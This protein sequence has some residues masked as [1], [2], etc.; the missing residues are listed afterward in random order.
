MLPSIFSVVIIFISI[1]SFLLTRSM[2]KDGYT[3]EKWFSSGAI[4]LHLLGLLACFCFI[5][6]TYLEHYW[7]SFSNVTQIVAILYR[8]NFRK[9]K[10]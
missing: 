9:T 2:R 10:K 1:F 8:L 3:G 4:H 6:N 5:E 7:D